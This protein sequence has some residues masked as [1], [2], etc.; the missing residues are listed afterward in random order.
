[1]MKMGIKDAKK[2]APVADD[3]AIVV[4]ISAIRCKRRICRISFRAAAFQ[5]LDPSKYSTQDAPS[6]P[7]RMK[8][9]FATVTLS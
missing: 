3:I 4:G 9:A 2:R 5:V 1:M 8:K 7:S 6:D